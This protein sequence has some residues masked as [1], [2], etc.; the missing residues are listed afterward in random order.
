[1]LPS[2]NGS[3]VLTRIAHTDEHL[4]DIFDLD[5]ATN[6]RL[7]AENNVLPGIT[8]LELVHGFLHYRIV[9]AAFCHARPEGSRFNGPDRGA[10]YGSFSYTTA[11][12]EILFHKIQALKEIN[13]FYDDVTYD[14]YWADFHNDFHDIRNNPAFKNC[15]QKKSYAASQKLA[16]TLLIEKQSAGIIYPSV[17]DTEGSNIVCFRPALVGNVRK[18]ATYRFRWEGSEKPVVEK[19]TSAL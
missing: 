7:L 2:K 5:N 19:A 8:A 11:E 15:L 18:K 3:S 17:R 10:W 9:N 16:H 13:Y 4:Q 6:D 12:Q 1:M 14:V